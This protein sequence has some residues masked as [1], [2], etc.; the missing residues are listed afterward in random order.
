MPGYLI[1]I[2]NGPATDRPNG[3]MTQSDD[4]R[5]V[6]TVVMDCEDCGGTAI[7]GLAALI[8]GSHE[9]AWAFAFQNLPDLEAWKRGN[10][11]IL[12]G[13]IVIEHAMVDGLQLVHS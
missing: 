9:G 5:T 2:L 11:T 6:A 7:V 1:V 3:T 10:S 12:Q 8:P 13:R 4:F